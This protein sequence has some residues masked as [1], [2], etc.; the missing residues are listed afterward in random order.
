MR[1]GCRTSWTNTYISNDW[2]TILRRSERR[3]QHTMMPIQRP[4]ET[5]VSK[6]RAFIIAAP[7]PSSS[8]A[9]RRHINSQQ[10]QQRH[11]PVTEL[12]GLKPKTASK[13][14]NRTKA[15]TGDRS[16]WSR[17]WWCGAGCI[18][19]QKPGSRTS[20]LR[21]N[22]THPDSELLAGTNHSTSRKRCMIWRNVR[23][24]RVSQK[25]W[26]RLF[27]AISK[28]LLEKNR[29]ITHLILTFTKSRFFLRFILQ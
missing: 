28:L 3:Q 13:R 21:N 8:T 29:F 19:Y 25:V 15:L 12:N 4:G 5:F 1:V 23:A 10:E 24:C 27:T 26:G 17:W 7:L 22:R 2:P 9:S 6:V 18:K 14:T 11:M 20:Q 16:E